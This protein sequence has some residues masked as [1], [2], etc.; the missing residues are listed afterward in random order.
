MVE[1]LLIMLLVMMKELK[2]KDKAKTALENKKHYDDKVQNN[3]V[4]MNFCPICGER[5]NNN[6]FCPK[7]GT[8]L[9]KK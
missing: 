5:N 3:V 9:I 8:L 7:C 4:I 1:R 6:R 2:G